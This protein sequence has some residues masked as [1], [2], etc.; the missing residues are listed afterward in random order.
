MAYFYQ[1]NILYY[2][3]SNML[4]IILPLAYTGTTLVN[5]SCPCALNSLQM[6]D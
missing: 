3:I 5:K 1:L 2:V 4:F 6:D